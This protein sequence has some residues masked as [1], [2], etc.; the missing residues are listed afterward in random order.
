M[1]HKKD[2]DYGNIDY[3]KFFNGLGIS[4]IIGGILYFIIRLVG[5]LGIH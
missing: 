1:K 4:W 5:T 2:F 3:D